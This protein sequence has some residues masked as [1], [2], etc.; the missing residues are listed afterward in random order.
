[1]SI[2]GKVPGCL[3]IIFVKMAICQNEVTNKNDTYCEYCLD[4]RKC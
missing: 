1:M 4:K 2:K 3:M